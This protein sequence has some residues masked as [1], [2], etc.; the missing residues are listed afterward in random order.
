MLEVVTPTFADMWFRES[1]MADEE[2]ICHIIMHGAEPSHFQKRNGRT[3]TTIG[4]SIMK[5]RGITG[6]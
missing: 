5:T 2:T 6:I 1:L 4:L 3:G